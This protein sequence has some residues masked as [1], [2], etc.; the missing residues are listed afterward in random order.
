MRSSNNGIN[1]DGV[2]NI[3][4]L[5]ELTFK[6]DFIIVANHTNLHTR[7]VLELAYLG[8]PLMIEKLIM[9]SL[10]DFTRYMASYFGK[11]GIRVN[12]VSLG[13]VFDNQPLDF[14]DNYISKT[15]LGRMSKPEDISPTVAFLLSDHSSYITGQNFIID[16]GFSII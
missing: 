13:G 4:H 15:P 16:G 8:V 3:Y 7:T 1:I 6:L 2:R 10:V 14:A 5:N 11:Y 12:T 9:D